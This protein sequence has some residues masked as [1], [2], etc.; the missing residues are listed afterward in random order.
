LKE[1]CRIVAEG[2]E[3]CNVSALPLYAVPGQWVNLDIACEFGYEIVGAVITKVNGMKT[4][5]EGTGFQMPVGEVSIQLK[6]ERIV[7]HVTFEVDGEVYS[8]ADYFLGEEIKLPEAP[9]KASDDTYSYEFLEWSPTVTIA[10]GEDRKPIYRAVFSKNLLNGVDPYHSGNNNNAFLNTYLPI[11]L[12]VVAIVVGLIIFLR[13]RKKRRLA[14]AVS[15]SAD[16][17]AA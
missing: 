3:F 5:V 4:E 16:D 13:V 2:S 7:Y 14:A 9:Q 12:G 10:M 17:T 1:A 8:Q 11:G 6:V 15:Q